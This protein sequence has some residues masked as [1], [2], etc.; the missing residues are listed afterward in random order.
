MRQ[1]AVC[2]CGFNLHKTYFVY[3]LVV[4]VKVR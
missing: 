2:F 3:V 1:V 4:L